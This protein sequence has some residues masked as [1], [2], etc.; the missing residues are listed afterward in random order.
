M[1]TKIFPICIDY[2]CSLKNFKDFRV[3]N[4]R[5]STIR[6]LQSVCRV[7]LK[8]TR[9]STSVFDVNQLSK[10]FKVQNER[11]VYCVFQH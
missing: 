1:Y 10:N 8:N 6:A 11:C 4:T 9:N 2:S 7:D 5:S 3:D